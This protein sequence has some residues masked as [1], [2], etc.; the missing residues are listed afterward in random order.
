[1]NKEVLKVLRLCDGAEISGQAIGR[2][3]GVSRTAVWKSVE[4]LRKMGFNINS[5]PGRGYVLETGPERLVGLDI[6]VGLDTRIIGKTV[7]SFE[8]VPS[9]IDVAS[10]VSREGAIEGTVVVAE[11]QTGGRGRLGRKW[12]SPPGVG[13][14]TS[15][16]LR[17]SV[18]PRDA[19][20]LTLLV[21]VSVAKVLKEQYGLDAG[22][23]WPNDVVVRNRKICGALTELVAEQDAVKYIIASFG[24]NVNQ[25]RSKFPA[26]VRSIATSMR[27]ETGTKFNRPEVFR[28]LLRELDEQYQYLKKHGDSH[29]LDQWRER[30]CTLGKHVKVQLRE[31]LVEGTARDLD[32]DGSLIVQVGADELRSVAYGD[33]TIL[34]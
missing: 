3:L 27:A 16:V 2:R 14:W 12:S 23:K 10:A 26:E 5:R 7:L 24:L 4:A 33:L 13:I 15:I 22:I 34:R 9:T 18:P 21:A 28:N 30:S 20:K 8:S 32:D 17:P 29:I 25:T 1:M 11:S 19:P 6:E 31:G